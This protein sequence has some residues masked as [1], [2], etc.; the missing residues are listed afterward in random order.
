MFLKN[1]QMFSPWQWLIT[2]I[3]RLFLSNKSYYLK[4]LILQIF[5]RLFH[6]LT[7][8]TQILVWWNRAKIS[9]ICVFWPE[10][11]SKRPLWA[12]LWNLN[13]FKRLFFTQNLHKSLLQV[14]L[15]ANFPPL[16]IV[17]LLFFPDSPMSCQITFWIPPPPNAYHHLCTTH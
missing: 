17:T 4:L 14:H 1:L 11:C 16:C 8:W 15:Y 12:T 7:D 5:W 10:E 3:F 2:A 6:D 9:F 13:I